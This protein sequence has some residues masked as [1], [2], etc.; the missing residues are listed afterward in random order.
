MANLKQCSRVALGGAQQEKHERAG[1]TPYFKVG[2]WQPQRSLP[3]P[4]ASIGSHFAKSEARGSPLSLQ[5]RH[6]HKPP[7]K[8]DRKR[9][10]SAFSRNSLCWS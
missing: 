7:S 5:R 10:T 6:Q 4:I 1:F 3:N 2:P 9:L 8:D